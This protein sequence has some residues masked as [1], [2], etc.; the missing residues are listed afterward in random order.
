MNAAQRQIEAA[1]V[2]AKA[3]GLIITGYRPISTAQPKHP[4]GSLV[5]RFDMEKQSVWDRMGHIAKAAHEVPKSRRGSVI[6][7]DVPQG[8][9][10]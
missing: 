6:H 2:R 9:L 5:L 8:E 1:A 3:K 10:L 4:D 7:D